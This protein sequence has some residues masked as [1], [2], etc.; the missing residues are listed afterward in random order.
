MK[1][2]MK[3]KIIEIIENCYADD[4]GHYS[5]RNKTALRLIKENLNITYND[6]WYTVK[7]YDET[8]KIYCN[9]KDFRRL[10]YFAQ[11]E[12]A[13]QIAKE[14]TKQHFKK[15]LS[16]ERKRYFEELNAKRHKKA[17]AELK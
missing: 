11:N 12:T 3:D 16:P 17:K 9:Q 13:L 10:E 14:L 1:K 8:M 2:T 4:K 6:H 7:I 15:E 5:F